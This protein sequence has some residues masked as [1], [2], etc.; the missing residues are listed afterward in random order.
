M[1]E[2]E[3]HQCLEKRRFAIS[4]PPADNDCWSTQLLQRENIGLLRERMEL[5]VRLIKRCVMERWRHARVLAE[6]ERSREQ[7]LM[8]SH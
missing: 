8:D 7:N 5:G 3:A 4:L 2:L 6:R 1:V